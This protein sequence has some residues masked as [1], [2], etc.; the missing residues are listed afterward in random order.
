MLRFVATIMDLISGLLAILAPIALIHWVVG[1]LH[2]DAISGLVG[3]FDLFFNP[4]NDVLKFLI[5]FNLP[6]LSFKGNDVTLYQPILAFIITLCFFGSAVIANTIR[7]M[8]GRTMLATNNIQYKEVS[9]ASPANIQST[10]NYQLL[11]YLLFPFDNQKTVTHYFSQ[12]QTYRGTRKRIRSEG[13]LIQFEDSYLGLCYL[14]DCVSKVVQYYQSLRVVDPRPPFQITAH[15]ISTQE[16]N[17]F[18]ALEQ[19]Q[20]MM[21][22]ASDNQVIVSEQVKQASSNG[23]KKATITLQS[24]GLYE[25][26][27]QKAQEIFQLK[28]LPQ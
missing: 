10:K 4:F 27:N 6:T 22:Y 2:I 19:C 14:N 13:W 16:T 5:P 18:Q 3:I 26:Q 8:D 23:H 28:P 12:Y 24:M 1:A 25:L 17:L 21:R 9:G 11:V 20:I 7:S 15:A